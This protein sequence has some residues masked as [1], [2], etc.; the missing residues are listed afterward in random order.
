MTPNR[1][2]SHSGR[3]GLLLAL[4]LLCLPLLSFAQSGTTISGTVTD[5]LG[6]PLPGVTVALEGTSVGTFTDADGTFTLSVS[7]STTSNILVF[8]YLGFG[9]QKQTLDFTQGNQTI[10][11]QLRPDITQ[12]DEIVVTGNSVS[13]SRKQLGNSIAS[14][15]AADLTNTGAVGV[16]QAL[17]GKVAG[18]L[19]TQNSGDPAGGISIRLRGAS[20]ISGS[21]DPLYIVDG[22]LVN[23]SSNQLVDLGGN[24]Q[25]RLVDLN[26]D[27]IERIEIIKGAA[28]AAIYGSRA[29]NGVVQIFTK[30]GKSGKPQISFTTG[31]RVNQ[32]RKE[33]D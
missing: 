6:D 12:L 30:R 21:S 32:L 8:S 17:S 14:L 31:L 28:A 10:N 2:H 18:A 3:N 7:A 29:S 19:V 16:D 27:D 22:V 13:T 23:N 1:L 24:T 11:M 15:Q 20:T 4:F 5:D 33:I 9:T 25:N 26:P